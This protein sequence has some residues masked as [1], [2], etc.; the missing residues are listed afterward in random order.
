MYQEVIRMLDKIYMGLDVGSTTVKAV[1]LDKNRNLIYST[2]E[3]HYSDIRS[4]VVSVIDKGQ[5]THRPRFH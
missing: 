1:V 4:T 3:R 5:P 2:Y